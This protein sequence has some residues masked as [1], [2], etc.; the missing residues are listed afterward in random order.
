MEF[1]GLFLAYGTWSVCLVIIL[2]YFYIVKGSL[3]DGIFGYALTAVLAMG[4]AGLLS[5]I[6]VFL[7]R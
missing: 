5:L 4:P 2:L 3:P 7:I 1:S 6:I